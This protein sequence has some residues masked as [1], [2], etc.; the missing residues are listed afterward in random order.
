MFGISNA[1]AYEGLMVNAKPP[2]QSA[3]RD[4]LGPSRRL[5]VQGP[6]D[7]KWCPQEGHLLIELLQQLARAGISSVPRLTVA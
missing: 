6:A 7:E 5:D 3:I 2:S 1:V 4:L